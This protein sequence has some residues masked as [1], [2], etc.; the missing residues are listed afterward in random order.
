[1]I[2]RVLDNR[3]IIEG[4]IGQGGMG[5]VYSGHQR[6][7]D[8]KV[9]IKTLRSSLADTDDFVDRFFREARVATTINHPHCVTIHDFGQDDDGTLYLA[10]EFLDGQELTDRIEAGSLTLE[11]ILRIGMQIASALSAAHDAQIVHRDLKPDNI[12]LLDIPGGGTFVKV[13]DFG[14]AKVLGSDTQMTKTGQVFGTPSY[15]S[16]EQCQGHPVDGRSDL[17]SLGC[18]LYELV[19]G[20]PPFN[21]ETPMAVLM[22]HVVNEVTPLSNLDGVARHVEPRVESLIMSL[23]AKEPDERPA[24]ASIARSQLEQIISELPAKTLSNTLSDLAALEVSQS[25]ELTDLRTPPQRQSTAELVQQA[26]LPLGSRRLL[27]MILGVGLLASLAGGAVLAWYFL[28]ERDDE[29]TITA[30]QEEDSLIGA[31]DHADSERPDDI[32]PG[33][34]IAEANT[35]DSDETA[36]GS[37]REGEGEGEEEDEDEDDDS[38]EDQDDSAQDEEEVQAEPTP[39]PRPRPRPRPQPRPEPRPT[40]QPQPEPQPEPEPVEEED[41]PL[42]FFDQD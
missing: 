39:E 27:V 37:P 9:A 23:L 12:F 38:V 29:T 16:P 41:D 20:R 1:M 5:A 24:T 4:K 2:G 42:D 21:G 30:V 18:I 26:G 19:G 14:I 35:D 10:M 22:A 34:E 13:L 6:S 17:Y 15:M 28:A 32:D 8:R 40:P 3:W 31:T 36:E 25:G 7:V 11:E 33:D